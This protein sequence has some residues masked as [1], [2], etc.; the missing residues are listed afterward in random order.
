MKRALDKIVKD[1][2][3]RQSGLKKQC[4]ETLGELTPGIVSE[5][6]G[7][8]SFRSADASQSISVRGG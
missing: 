3:R 5:G 7:V 2:P 1:C 8:C 4:R 6:E